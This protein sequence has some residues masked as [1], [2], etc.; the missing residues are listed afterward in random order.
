MTGLDTDVLVR[1]IAQDDPTQSPRATWFIEKECSTSTPGFVGVVV[2]VD[3]VWVSESCCGAAR[4][5]IAELVRRV[6]S[7]KQLVVQDTETVWKALRLFESGKSRF[8]RLFN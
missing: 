7:M 4:N 6:L 8:S 1:Y 2:L 5:E 3:V